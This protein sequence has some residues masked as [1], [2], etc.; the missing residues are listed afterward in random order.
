MNKYLIRSSFLV[1]MM[2]S[3]MV[4]PFVF[5]QG[6]T[7]KIVVATSN[8]RVRAEATSASEQV[9][10]LAVGESAVWLGEKIDG[11][12]V[13]G[14]SLWYQIRLATGIEGW[15][16]SGA[17]AIE[18]VIPTATP[19]PR[20]TLP[21]NENYQTI[22][23]ENVG[24][25]RSAYT[26][27]RGLPQGVAWSPDGS[28]ILIASSTGLWLHDVTDLSAPP[29][30]VAD[31]STTADDVTYV[32][33]VGFIPN[34]TNIY[35][36]FFGTRTG[37]SIVFQI[38]NTKNSALGITLNLEVRP[39][40]WR[41]AG[42][43]QSVSLHP[44]G[45]ILAL[46]STDG[47][48]LITMLSDSPDET[49]TRFDESPKFATGSESYNVLYSPDGTQLAVMNGNGVSVYT[50]PDQ[51]LLSSNQSGGTHFLFTPDGES[52]ILLGN[53]MRFISLA[54]DSGRQK[55]R[56]ERTGYGFY[57]GAMNPTKPEFAT[58]LSR[59]P[60]G[61][62]IY[63]ATQD[64]EATRYP[65][66]D[67]CH[68]LAYSPDGKFLVGL[69]K[70]GGVF[71]I[72]DAETGDIVMRDSTTYSSRAGI[73]FIQNGAQMVVSGGNQLDFYNPNDPDGELLQTVSYPDWEAFGGV[74]DPS[75]EHIWAT[76]MLPVGMSFEMVIQQLDLN[77]TPLGDEKRF[78]VNVSGGIASSPFV[79]FA[80]TPNGQFLV[81]TETNGSIRFRN[82]ITFEPITV[83]YHPLGGVNDHLTFSDDGAYFVTFGKDDDT[84][85]LWTGA[86]V[87]VQT[88]DIPPSAERYRGFTGLSISADGSRV[89]FSDMY[90]F[91]VW[92]TTTGDRMFEMTLNTGEFM[93]TTTISPDGQMLAMTNSLTGILRVYD[94]QTGDE[95]LRRPATRAISQLAFTPDG[96]LLIGISDSDGIIRF[97]GVSK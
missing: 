92:D 13:G 30:K 16:W 45:R 96:A 29:K 90:S 7:V 47:V 46:T 82:P 93:G 19:T 95:L 32:L 8:A 59:I 75:G 79:S 62:Y 97:W 27:G 69:S 50:M 88:F 3:L 33:Q 57:D 17:V 52:L 54:V 15:V 66:L 77:G 67:L 5:G 73:Q 34:T 56:Y 64:G 80:Y 37:G 58:A 14:N 48:R 84:V 81:T 94:V 83:A 53:N 49:I 70:F 51:T 44:D 28:Q 1:I 2:M 76:A 9:G 38:Y 40:N 26:W 35:A 68:F 71:N 63:D 11:E 23:T 72:W 60:Y 18:E 43:T 55:F 42:T 89:A 41:I 61:A 78:D 74:V 10:T 24:N 86:G 4:I 12:N 22:T 36:V 39:L 20:P 85:R 65:L 31:F 91:Y 25:L 21:P 87:S 6:T